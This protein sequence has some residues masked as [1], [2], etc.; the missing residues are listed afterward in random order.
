M[1]ET[2]SDK[3]IFGE[4]KQMLDY[5]Y[6]IDMLYHILE[7]EMFYDLFSNIFPELSM[8]YLISIDLYHGPFSEYSEEVKTMKPIEWFGEDHGFVIKDNE[9]FL[10]TGVTEYDVKRFYIDKI[11]TDNLEM[12]R[13]IVSIFEILGDMNSFRYNNCV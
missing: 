1:N 11:D 2:G 3:K 9:Y 10:L 12:A 6:D 13:K 8:K 4:V 7:D 5:L